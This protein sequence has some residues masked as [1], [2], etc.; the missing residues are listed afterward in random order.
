MTKPLERAAAAVQRLL[1]LLPLALLLVLLRL[2]L[3]PLPSVGLALRLVGRV[4][5]VVR[6]LGPVLPVVRSI[7]SR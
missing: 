2:L 4:E 3:F 7:T 6:D 5:L 1:L